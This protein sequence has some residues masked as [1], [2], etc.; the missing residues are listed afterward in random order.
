MAPGIRKQDEGRKVA[1]EEDEICES[2]VATQMEDGIIYLMGEIGSESA[3][4]T[5]KSIIELN[6]RDDLKFIR[7]VIN[8]HGGNL[9]DAFA[10]ID[11]MRGSKIPVHTMALG[12]AFSAAAFILMAGHKGTRTVTNSTSIMCHRYWKTTS[13]NYSDLVATRKQENLDH[14]RMVEAI[15]RCS[16][17]KNRADVESSILK[18]TDTWLT[19]MEAKR[20]GLI[21]KVVGQ[22][23]QHKRKRG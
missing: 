5:I 11:T 9:Y 23:K 4:N 13:G 12:Q 20:L 2:A 15:I 7:L 8:S 6:K 16:K 17:L 1:E 22:R 14:R 3:L 21:D 10:I 19:P 18:D